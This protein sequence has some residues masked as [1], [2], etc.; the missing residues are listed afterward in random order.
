MKKAGR[1]DN[2]K[3]H[4]YCNW[5]IWYER[6]I[7]W[8]PSTGGEEFDFRDPASGNY[9]INPRKFFFLWWVDEK[10]PDEY[11]SIDHKIL[12]KRLDIG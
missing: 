2:V 5:R 9:L 1:G 8:Q 7:R 12:Q 6:Y 4:A 11:R 3:I 10:K